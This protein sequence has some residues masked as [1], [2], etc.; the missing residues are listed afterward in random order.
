MVVINVINMQNKIGVSMMT[1]LKLT[2]TTFSMPPCRLM[3]LLLFCSWCTC[4]RNHPYV[5][6]FF[7]DGRL[8]TAINIS[9]S[10]M[11]S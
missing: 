7:L 2:M 5:G 8:P 3:S 10:E 11:L 9:R 1:L 4:P 6:N